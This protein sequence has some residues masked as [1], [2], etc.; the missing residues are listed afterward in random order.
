MNYNYYNIYG[1]TV[2]TTQKIN[3]LTPTNNSN[4]I[5][6]LINFETQQTEIEYNFKNKSTKIYS[7]YGLAQNKIPYLTVWK[8]YENKQEFLIIRYNNAKETAFFVIDSNGENIKAIYHP[9]ILIDDIIT[10]LLGPVIGCV[11]RLKNKVCLHASVV[12]INEKAVA[13]IGEKTAGKSTLI[14]NFAALGYPILSD[15]IA[16]VIKKDNNYFIEL[17]YP[18]LRLWKNT[19][20]NLPEIDSKGL[21]NVLS[22]VEKYY[23]PLS[24]KKSSIWKFQSKPL[25]LD[26]IYYLQPRN[27]DNICQI[28]DC[29]PLDSFIKLKKNIYAEYM[30][31][32]SLKT[33]EFEVFGELGSLNKVKLLDRM[34][35]LK[36]IKKTIQLIVNN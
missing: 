6:V 9:N 26:K 25:V 36:S 4:E 3:H 32:S 34:N 27:E 23:L 12:N 24:I 20:E 30:L 19:I 33:E 18:R 15:D 16:V 14:A 11:L 7:S 35:D 1:L 29:S 2:K 5:D 28:K 22:G 13:F 31:E 8:Q 17:G 10:Y 21:K